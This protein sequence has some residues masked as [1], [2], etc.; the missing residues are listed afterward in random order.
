MVLLNERERR[1]KCQISIINVLV[2]VSYKVATRACAF[3]TAL[4]VRHLYKE[5]D[6]YDRFYTYLSATPHQSLFS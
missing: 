2:L 1:A 6:D 4:G 3:N 5:D